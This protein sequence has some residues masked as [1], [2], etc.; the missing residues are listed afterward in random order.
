MQNAAPYAL[1]ERAIPA[2]VL[3]IENVLQPCSMCLEASCY[4]FHF[5]KM[6]EEGDVRDELLWL[7]AGLE[8]RPSA[9]IPERVVIGSCGISLR[10]NL[11]E[12]ALRFLSKDSSS[13]LDKLPD[14]FS[15]NPSF[16]DLPL[17]ADRLFAIASLPR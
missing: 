8:I 9:G 11:S 12:A 15:H 1:D 14:S 7:R 5:F 13:V 2:S 4:A 10:S 16:L 3:V 17:V 6:L